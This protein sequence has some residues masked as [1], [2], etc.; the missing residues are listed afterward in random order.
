MA[1][2]AQKVFSEGWIEDGNFRL[3]LHKPPDERRIAYF[4]NFSW[5]RLQGRGTV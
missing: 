1:I 4:Y 5:N 2:F 3:I